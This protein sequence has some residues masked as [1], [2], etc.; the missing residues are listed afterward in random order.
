MALA[1]SAWA[2]TTF[3]GQVVEAY[4]EADIL[5][6]PVVYNFKQGELSK[7]FPKIAARNASHRADGSL[8]IP[9]STVTETAATVTL[10]NP[11]GVAE[12]VKY[13]DINENGAQVPSWYAR[14]LGRDLAEKRQNVLISWFLKVATG[15]TTGSLTAGVDVRDD[16]HGVIEFDDDT[17]DGT[18]VA[19]AILEAG[20]RLSA[21]KVPTSG[22]IGVLHPTYFARLRK[23]PYVVSKD[24]ASNGSNTQPFEV[25][26]FA[27]AKWMSLASVFDTDISGDTTYAARYR[28]NFNDVDG[29]HAWGVLFQDEGAAIHEGERPRGLIDD[30]PAYST[31]LVQAR[32]QF[33]L[34]TLQTKAFVALVGD[35]N[36]S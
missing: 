25:L 27:G 17:T 35:S 5:G 28:A 29:G 24:Y 32:N 21:D 34:G 7:R 10:D 30:V 18:A 3:G 36:N 33:G 16:G 26:Y 2:L 11:L 22:R 20:A 9:G 1:V 8:L 4:K 31:W 19:D 6:N 15:D 23:V 14:S 13:Q 12:S